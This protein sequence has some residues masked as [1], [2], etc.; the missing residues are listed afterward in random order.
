LEHVTFYEGLVE[1]CDPQ[2]RATKEGFV[3]ASFACGMRV[4]EVKMQVVRFDPMTRW[5]APGLYYQ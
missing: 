5:T 3:I 4:L 2:K 1:G